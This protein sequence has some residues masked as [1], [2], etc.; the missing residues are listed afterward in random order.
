MR[1]P[2]TQLYLH[3]VWATWD[4]E[5]LLA[6][7]LER[8][9]YACIQAKCRELKTE[10]IALGGIE[11]HVHLLVR[12][13]AII[14]VA[15]LVK[16][17]KGASSHLATHCVAGGEGFKWQGAYGAFTVSKGD[18]PRIK[19]YVLNQPEHHREGGLDQDLEFDPFSD[20]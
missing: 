19:A 15:H 3:V 8:P 13:P 2:F 9:I 1:E 11:D 5:P 17:V 12:F 16:E 18:V 4:R 7:E 14:A 6:P 20:P 10:V